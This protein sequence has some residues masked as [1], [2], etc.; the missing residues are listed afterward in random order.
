[1]PT[2]R[3]NKKSADHGELIDWPM[4]ISMNDISIISVVFI[5]FDDARLVR[6]LDQGPGLALYDNVHD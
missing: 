5:L 2:E 6:D 1:M 3:T 4:R